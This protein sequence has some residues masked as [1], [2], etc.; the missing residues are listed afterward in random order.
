MATQTAPLVVNPTEPKTANVAL[1]AAGIALVVLGQIYLVFAKSINWDEFLHLSQIHDLRDGR[2]VWAFQVLHTR[3]FYWLPLVTSDVI[4]QVQIARLAMLGFELVTIAAI[5]GLARLF[6]SIEAAL[7]T[8]LAY[9]SGGYVFLHGFSLRPDPIF[10]ALMMS[11]LWLA[12][13]QRLRFPTA[14]VI[15]AL[16]GISGAATIKSVLY[17]PC[18][19]GIIWW[20]LADTENRR[21]ALRTV[22]IIAVLAPLVFAPAPRVRLSSRRSVRSAATQAAQERS[23]LQGAEQL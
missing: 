16:I 20:R 6:V 8:S 2:L 1:I 13:T 10:T 9:I 18:F 17:L 4:Q 14:L 23:P 5:Y 15:S 11:A 7:L 21:Q 12:A 3:I 22:A 19:A